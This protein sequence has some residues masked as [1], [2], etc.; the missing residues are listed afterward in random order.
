MCPENVEKLLE[1]TSFEG[2]KENGAHK[3]LFGFAQ[4]IRDDRCMILKLV[5]REMFNAKTVIPSVLQ[6]ILR[7]ESHMSKW[8]KQ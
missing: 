4:N 5:S 2:G 8:P 1:A 3:A 7:F 6:H